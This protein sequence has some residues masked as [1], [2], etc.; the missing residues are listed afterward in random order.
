MN[1]EPAVQPPMTDDPTGRRE[2][3]DQLG[4]WLGGAVVGAIALNTRRTSAAKLAR[5]C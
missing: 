3:L 2:M 1:T 5:L 4:Q